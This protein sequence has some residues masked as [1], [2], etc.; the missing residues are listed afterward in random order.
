MMA[1]D[2]LAD[3]WRVD[4]HRHAPLSRMIEV[5]PR[6]GTL[7]L[8]KLRA[9]NQ[10][11]RELFNPAAAPKPERPGNFDFAHE[12]NLL[13]YRGPEIVVTVAA[14]DHSQV[15]GRRFPESRH[16]SRRIHKK[17]LKRHGGEFIFKPACFQIGDRI[18][19]HPELQ[20]E[21]AEQMARAARDRHDDLVLATLYGISI[22]R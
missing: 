10:R 19:I 15:I 4:I 12:Q 18:V 8:E 7:T 20:R 13:R 2:F 16:R 9:V 14:V 21:L 17:L 1:N 3:L 6:E 5:A 11:A 22:F